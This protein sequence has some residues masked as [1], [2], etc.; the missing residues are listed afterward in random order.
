MITADSAVKKLV[1]IAEV[2]ATQ[3]CEAVQEG[4]QPC[5]VTSDKEDEWCLPCLA[6]KALE[7]YINA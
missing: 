1:D 5:P 4:E 7:Q 6:K 2:L 3:E